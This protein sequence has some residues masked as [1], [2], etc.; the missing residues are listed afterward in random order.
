MR[1]TRTI[2]GLWVVLSLVSLTAFGQ[3]TG[4]KLPPLKIKQYQLKNGL[5][6]VLH[7]DKSTPVVAVNVWYHVGSKNEEPGRTGFAHLFEHMMFQGSKNYNSD[8]FTPLQEAGANINGTTNTD[9]TWYYETVP[10]NFLELAL[11]LEADRMG[12]L[13]EAM[14]QDKLDNQRDVVKNERRQ[15]V[16]NQPYGTAFE[17]IASTM[18]PKGH[19]YNWTTIGSLEDLQAATL[20]DVKGF[21]RRYYVPNNAVLV[22]AGDF[23]EKQA[24]NWIEKYFG[25]IAQGEAITRPTNPMPKLDKEIRASFE[26][27]VP[28]ARRYMVWHTAP[29]YSA[30]EPAL[31]MLGYILSTG[32]TS[33]LQSKLVYEKEMVQQVNANN[34]TS[35][36]GGTF[37][38]QA[39][40]RPGKSLDDIEKEINAEIERIKTEP[41]TADEL[42]RAK[43]SIEAQTVFGLQTV[44]GKGSQIGT[45]SGYLNKPDNFQAELDRYA[46]VT[47]ADI[48]RVANTYLGANRLVMTYT[49]RQGEAQRAARDADRPTSVKTEK[50]DDSA[51]KAQAAKLPKSGPDPKLTLPPIEK[52]KLSNGLEVWM[53]EQRELPIVA[54]N[55][56]LKSGIGNEPDDRTGVANMTASLIDDGT[57]TRSAADIANQIQALGIQNFSAGSGWDSTNVSMLTL[58]KNLDAALDLYSDVLMHPS[59][60]DKELE[61]FRA[62]SLIGLRQQKA[63]P[64]VVSNNV[65]NKVLYGDHPYGRDNTEATIKAIT[66]ADL[67]KF[68]ESN[69]RPNNGVL[70]VVGDINKPTLKAKLEKTFANWKPADVPNREL[71]ATRGLEKT[72]IYLVDRPNSAQSVVSIGQIGLERSNPDYFPVVVMNSILGGGFTARI[73]MNLRED[74]GYTY[75]ARS[76]FSFRRGAGPFSAGGDIQTAVTKEAIVEFMKELNDIRGGRPVTQEELDYNK[77]SLIRRYPGG[78]ETVGSMSNQ[79]ANLVVYGLPDSYFNEYISKVNAV[80]LSDVNRVA[81]KYLDPAKMAIVIV[82]DRKVIEPGLKQLGYSVTILDTEG[83]PVSE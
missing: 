1:I 62:R 78:F 45:F 53:V 5:K 61:S 8:Y 74:K 52:T 68:Y 28:L 13:L 72:A 73:N 71:P 2:V 39:T 66:R 77:Q 56:V 82:G 46:R 37:G 67:V 79:L 22:L 43:N 34:N 3:K 23:D 64:N 17:R 50:K 15:R 41:P 35:E 60:P 6:V 83:K 54:F 32:R 4:D 7:E 25:P 59:F 36:I 81:T 24:R 49:P 76:G 19:P 18:Y 29:Q 12:G 31:D 47:S 57:Q 51:V 38:I 80:S 58:N 44:L 16:D 11:F 27:A 26:D 21:F 75:G 65:Y 30:D 42:T 55:L 63:N 9:R 20:D 40:A 70:I 10:S 33:R 69:Y 48:Q 14:T